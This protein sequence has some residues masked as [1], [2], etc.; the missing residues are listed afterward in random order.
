MY[1]HHPSEANFEKGVMLVRGDTFILHPEAVH[2]RD[3]MKSCICYSRDGFREDSATRC[4]EHYNDRC[5]C[6]CVSTLFLVPGRWA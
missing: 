3:G 1:S 2:R 5:A 4:F 6:A